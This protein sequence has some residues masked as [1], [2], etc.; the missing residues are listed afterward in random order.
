MLPP[1]YFWRGVGLA[2]GL[3]LTDAQV[4][5]LEKAYVTGQSETDALERDRAIAARDLRA[6]LQAAH[7]SSADITAAGQRFR[8]LDDKVYEHQL[9]MLAAV[10]EVLSRE[11]WEQL[12][13]N[14]TTDREPMR[15]RGG[16]GGGRR[17]GRRPGMGRP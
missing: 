7:P 11:Q 4:A 17:G 9:R 6:I 10:R 8:V 12:Q 5:E 2:N 15:E 3:D 14:L 16:F 13:R 1:A